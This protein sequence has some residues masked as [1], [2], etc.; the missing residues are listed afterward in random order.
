MIG[1]GGCCPSAVTG[2]AARLTATKMMA[3]VRGSFLLTSRLFGEP[4]RVQARGLC[5]FASTATHPLSARQQVQAST[6]VKLGKAA[7]IIKVK[8]AQSIWQ[9]GEPHRVWP[10]RTSALDV[11]P[12]QVIPG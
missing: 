3:A 5:A 6:A 8:P 1:I 4:L 10:P 11:E 7:A 12:Q 9:H 2:H